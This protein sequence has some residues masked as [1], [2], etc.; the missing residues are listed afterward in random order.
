MQSSPLFVPTYMYSPA[1]AKVCVTSLG[2]S[3]VERPRQEIPSLHDTAGACQNADYFARSGREPPE[4]SL[5][6]RRYG[7]SPGRDRRHHRQ[8][9][10]TVPDEAF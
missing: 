6:A 9:H 8:R 10:G 7:A 3:L 1:S 4:W 5:T 2:Q